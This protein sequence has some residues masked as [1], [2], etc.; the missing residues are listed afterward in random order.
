MTPGLTLG[1][2]N[3]GLTYGIA[4]NRTLTEKEAF[5]ILEKA[6]ELGVS[7]VDTARG[8][9]DAEKV[10]G[11]FF[12]QH[13][14]VFEVVSKLP[15]GEYRTSDDVRRQ[16][17]ASLENLGVDRIDALLLHSFRSFERF[18]YV[19]LPVFESYFSSGLIGG[20]G[21]SVYH[22]YEVETAL[23][24]GFRITA[25]QFPLNL[26]DQRFLKGGY[27]QKF[28]ASGISLY[29][30]SIFLQGLFFVDGASLGDHFDQAKPKLKH[31]ASMARMHGTSVE[32]LALL[33]AVSSGVD[34]V[35]LGVDNGEQL[36]KD[37]AHMA[38]GIAELLPRLKQGFDMLEISNEEI[39]LPF[40]WKQ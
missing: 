11:K 17:D 22:P 5:A 7:S 37:V 36:E 12:A 26:F 38:N 1:T 23:R 10:L 14:K 16:V 3:F 25:V 27:I 6:V 40:R 2:A 15:D 31:L 19:L 33:F 21:L 8:Y 24:A 32:A 20:Y 9:G 34:H 29:A 18:K 28:R 30:R 13:G 35:V 39:I 4:N